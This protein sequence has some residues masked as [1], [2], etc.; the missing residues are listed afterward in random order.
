MTVKELIEYLKTLNNNL[1]I[2]LPIDD[3]SG[4]ELEKKDIIYDDEQLIFRAIE[5]DY[6]DS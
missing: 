4:K 5:E 2:Y 1:I 3:F 6:Y